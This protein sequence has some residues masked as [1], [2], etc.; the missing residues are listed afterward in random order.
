MHIY[1]GI[2]IPQNPASSA[3]ITLSLGPPSDRPAVCPKAALTPPA[4]ATHGQERSVD[5]RAEVIGL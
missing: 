2:T 1:D 5:G 3:P 4:P